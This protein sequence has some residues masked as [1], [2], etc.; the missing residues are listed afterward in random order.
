MAKP[1]RNAFVAIGLAVALTLAFFISPLASSSP[2]GLE[3]VAAEKGLDTGETPHAAGDGPLAEYSFS[4]VDNERVSTGLS[5]II[6][7]VLVF[8]VGM[9][10]FAVLKFLRRSTVTATLGRPDRS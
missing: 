9:G 6:G 7:V 3:K 4:G 1:S 5:G 2:D 10:A 8:G